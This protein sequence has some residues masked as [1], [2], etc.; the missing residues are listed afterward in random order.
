MIYTEK[1]TLNS[2]WN[3]IYFTEHSWIFEEEH[4]VKL[5]F[6]SSEFAHTLR[7]VNP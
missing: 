1:S 6:H 4:M 7:N 5:G 3:P 2:P